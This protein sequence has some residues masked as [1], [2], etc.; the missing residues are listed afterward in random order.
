VLPHFTGILIRDGY[1]GYA[2]LP[3]VH[4]WCGAHLLRDLRSISDADPDAQLWALAMADTLLEA[5]HDATDARARGAEALDE[6][7]LARIRNHY[8]GALARGRADNQGKPGTLAAQARTLITRF[9]RFEDMI[10]RFATDLVPFTNNEARTSRPARQSPA[11]NL[12]RRLAH[13]AR[14][15]R[16]RHRPVLPGHRHQV[17]HR[18]TPRPPTAVHH[19]TL[20]ATRPSPQ[21]NSYGHAVDVDEVG[22]HRVAEVHQHE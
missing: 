1:A 22:V 20:A 14:T 19:R 18:Q 2:H 5:H 4:A 6:A 9:T 7:V 13:P 11:A 16:L 12:R 3:A 15:D 8:H 10:L 21:L 17:G